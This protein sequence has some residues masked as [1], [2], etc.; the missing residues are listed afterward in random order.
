VSLNHSII[1][2]LN[3]CGYACMC[4]SILSSSGIVEFAFK[5]TFPFPKRLG[6][7]G[8][9]YTVVLTQMTKA[10]TRGQSTIKD[11]MA[12]HALYKCPV[13]G[14]LHLLHLRCYANGILCLINGLLGRVISVKTDGWHDTLFLWMWQRGQEKQ[15]ERS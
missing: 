8:R 2:K 6:L 7:H 12:C 1:N 13:F 10:R 3:R 5:D 11:E 4:S 14:F 15:A 9:S